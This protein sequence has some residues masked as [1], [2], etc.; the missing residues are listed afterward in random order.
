MGEGTCGWDSSGP[1][2]GRGGLG[3]AVSRED[4]DGLHP[5]SRE[6]GGVAVAWYGGVYVV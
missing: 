4:L 2:L 5:S 6:S 3:G 1:S